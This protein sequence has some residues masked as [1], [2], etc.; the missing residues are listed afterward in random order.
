MRILH[1]TAFAISSRVARKVVQNV[2]IHGMLGGVFALQFTTVIGRV[3]RHE[4]IL[5][6]DI[7]HSLQLREDEGRCYDIQQHHTE[8]DRNSAIVHNAQQSRAVVESAEFHLS[9]ALVDAIETRPNY[10]VAHHLV[11]H[12][13]V[14]RHLV[15]KVVVLAML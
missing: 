14:V 10:A 9:H 13:S 1:N 2:I 15:E 7:V 4:D 3:F 5:A 12:V 8:Q 11:A 6:V